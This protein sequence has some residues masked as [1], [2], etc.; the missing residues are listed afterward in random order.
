MAWRLLVMFVRLVC[1]GSLDSGFDFGLLVCLIWVFSFFLT[2]GVSFG[3]GFGGKFWF[4]LRIWEV[5]VAS[6]FGADFGCMRLGDF[7][8]FA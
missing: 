1:L 2:G 8:G 5:V 6:L 7:C 3:V 4:G